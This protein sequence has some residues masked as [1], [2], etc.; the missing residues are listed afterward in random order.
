M[1]QQ[2]VVQHGLSLAEARRHCWFMDSQGLVCASR[3]AN[4]AHHKLPFAHDRWG[5]VWVL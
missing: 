2:L 1:A 3:A 4:L 5:H